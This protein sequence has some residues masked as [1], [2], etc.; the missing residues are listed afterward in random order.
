MHSLIQGYH[1]TR[2]ADLKRMTL[3]NE[4]VEAQSF[5]PDPPSNESNTCD[6]VILPLLLAA[7]YSRRDIESRI[8]DSTG[9]FPDYTI[10]PAAPGAIWY[11]EAKA[12]GVMLEDIHAK[13]ALNY[14][15]HNG[16]RFV[17]LTN[18]QSWRLYDNSIQ[19]VLA[20]KLISCAALSDTATITRFL[21]AL[22]KTDVLAGSLERFAAN[23]MQHKMEAAAEYRKQ[24]EREHEELRA[25]Q[26]LAELRSS[27]RAIV[28]AEFQDANSD[29]V[30]VLINKLRERTEF[31][32]ITSEVL[33]SVF[34]DS[35]IAPVREVASIGRNS[36][37]NEVKHTANRPR[38]GGRRPPPTPGG[39]A[40]P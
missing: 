18:G 36:T 37:V 33:T 22:S 35:L 28:L 10:L 19:G 13:Q 14:A 12:W 4:I 29:I 7:G 40:G 16:K 21:Y 31:A 11:L 32:D 15:N 2:T 39:S 6:W 27:V 24:K 23:E 17:V 26:R 38:S 3:D 8:A 34:A 9:Q 5:F 25:Q 30:S 1:E 20:D